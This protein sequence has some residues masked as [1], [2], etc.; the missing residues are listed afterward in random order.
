MDV[1]VIVCEEDDKEVGYNI[2]VSMVCC[3]C[4]KMRRK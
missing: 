2:G 1:T 4:V 3:F